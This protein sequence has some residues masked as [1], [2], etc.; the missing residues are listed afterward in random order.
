MTDKVSKTNLS[1]NDRDVGSRY[2]HLLEASSVSLIT[3][4]VPLEPGINSHSYMLHCY[5]I[6]SDSYRSPLNV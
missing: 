1:I 5:E 4:D 2:I 6:G 3:D